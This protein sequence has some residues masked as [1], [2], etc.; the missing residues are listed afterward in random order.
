MEYTYQNLQQVLN[1][2][3]NKSCIPI[4]YEQLINRINNKNPE[5]KISEEDYDNYLNLL[6]KEYV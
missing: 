5:D 4:L 1:R 3:I 6:N 2:L